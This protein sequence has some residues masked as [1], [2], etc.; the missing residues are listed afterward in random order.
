MVDL[1]QHYHTTSQQLKLLTEED[2][3][4][5][6]LGMSGIGHPCT[7]YIWYTFRQA[8]ASV[9][10][11]RIKHIFRRGDRIEEG[12]IEAL[13]EI[14]I[15]YHTDYSQ[16]EIVDG[17]G[18]IKGHVDGVVSHVPEAPKTLHLLEIKSMK[19]SSFKDYIKKGLKEY[20]AAYWAQIQTYMMHLRL[21]RTL[22]IVVNKNTDEI[23]AQRYKLDMDDA[24]K[25]LKRGKT[26]VLSETPPP[27][28]FNKTYYMC[29]WCDA[30][31]ICHE[32]GSML[33]SCRTCKYVNVEHEGKWSC[34]FYEAELPKDFMP[35]G[36][37]NHEPIDNT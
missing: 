22:Y 24:V 5:D 20:S 10:P 21:T 8:Y 37:N 30:Y 12:V 3:H 6:Y 34:S 18:H 23:S 35:K 17:F 9:K 7:R 2:E 4:R 36:C 25:A 15:K 33:K 31:N 16:Y 11:K 19:E 14:G 27:R 13:Q 1:K 26:V 28:A 29:K 32:S